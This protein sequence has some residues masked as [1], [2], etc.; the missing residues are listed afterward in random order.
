MRYW[1]IGLIVINNN[2]KRS[3]GSDPSV[4]HINWIR[5]KRRC[6]QPEQG[7]RT[8]RRDIKRYQSALVVTSHAR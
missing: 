3:D 4:A 5:R 8:R 1:R 6:R 7:E 2:F